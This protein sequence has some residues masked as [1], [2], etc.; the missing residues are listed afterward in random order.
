MAVKP[1]P[2]GYPRV[3]PV[4]VVDG[5]AKLL[6]FIKTAFGGQERMRMPMP[7]GKVAHAEI[8]IGDSLIMVADASPQVAAGQGNI[9]LYVENVDEVYKRALAAGAR[10]EM[11]LA[12]QFYGE[13]SGSVR[14]EFG[15]RW[16]LATHIE[17]VSEEEMMRRMAAMG[18]PPS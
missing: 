7:D 6:D 13:R 11:E 2:D 4:L 8:T 3:T 10:S 16:S 9:F 12:D 14:D 18:P 17:D 5:A 1:I 15:N